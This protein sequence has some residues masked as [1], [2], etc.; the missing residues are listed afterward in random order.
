MLIESGTVYE[1]TQ[2]LFASTY[3]IDEERQSDLQ[4]LCSLTTNS[5]SVL[6]ETQLLWYIPDFQNR[7]VWYITALNGIRTFKDQYNL[8]LRTEMAKV[9]I[10]K[11]MCSS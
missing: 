9:D 5:K 3:V 4:S 1:N 7:I 6:L 10:L 11:T 8:I 2:G